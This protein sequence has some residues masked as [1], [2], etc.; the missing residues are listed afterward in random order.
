MVVAIV[1][2]HVA[3]IIALPIITNLFLF[4]FCTMN[5]LKRCTK[6]IDINSD[7]N[8]RIHCA[9]IYFGHSIINNTVCNSTFID[10]L[11]S[12]LGCCYLVI[13]FATQ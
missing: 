12:M 9:N 3:N 5:R 13:A 11:Y 1:H 10:I 7:H 4:N 6:R 2:V 8:V